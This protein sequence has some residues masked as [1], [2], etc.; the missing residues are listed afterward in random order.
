MAE[1]FRF[2]RFAVG[3]WL[4]HAGLKALPRGRCRDEIYNLLAAWGAQVRRA[5]SDGV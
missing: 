4:I 1:T 3:R 2:V 5:L